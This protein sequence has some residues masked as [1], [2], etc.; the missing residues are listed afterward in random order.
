MG[1]VQRPSIEI[2]SAALVQTYPV[3]LK[4]IAS[5]V[6]NEGILAEVRKL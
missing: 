3:H 5:N 4:N 1:M 6:S 2:F